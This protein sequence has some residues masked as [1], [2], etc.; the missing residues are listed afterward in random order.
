MWTTLMDDLQTIDGPNAR[1]SLVEVADAGLTLRLRGLKG[2]PGWTMPI[3]EA[4]H[5]SGVRRL[6]DGFVLDIDVFPDAAV[7]GHGRFAVSLIARLA[8]DSSF[9]EACLC[10][11][12]I[13]AADAAFPLE[14]LAFPGRLNVDG[15]NDRSD[16][17]YLL[18]YGEGI[19][20]DADG[21]APHAMKQVSFHDY[22]ITMPLVA[23]LSGNGA[24]VMAITQQGHDHGIRPGYDGDISLQL[25]QLACLGTWRYDRSWRMVTIG[26][27]GV[28]TLAKIARSELKRSGLALR[29]LRDKVAALPSG[30]C[31][32]PGG[33]HLWCHMDTLTTQLVSD[34]A[35]TGIRALMVMGRPADS[36]A[37]TTVREA[38]FASGPY[39]Q[40]YDV[41]PPGSVR[42]LEWR[43]T[44]PPEGASHGFPHQLRRNRDGFFDYAWVHLPMAHSEHHWAFTDA[45]GSDGRVVR[46]T[47]AIHEQY[48]VQSYRRC[49]LFHREV[50]AEYGLPMLDKLGSTAVF[51]DICTTMFGLECADPRHPCERRQDVD[52][53]KKALTDFIDTQRIVMSEDGKWWAVDLAHGFEGGLNYDGMESL[54]NITLTDYEFNSNNWNTEFNLEHRIPFFSMIMGHTVASTF[55]WG[56]G[57]DRHSETRRAKDAFAALLGGNPI[58]VVDPAHPLH[59]GTARWQDFVDTAKAFDVL[60]NHTL[61]VPI[62]RFDV[63]G[64]HHGTTRF[65]NGVVVDANVGPFPADGLDAGEYRVYSPSGDPVAGNGPAARA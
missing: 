61:G 1:L 25:V 53:R 55:W 62:D 26:E 19:L 23:A 65:E 35:A 58:F 33:T 34:L 47:H 17:Q 16:W 11:I 54:D 64:K 59:S 52:L 10:D 57:Q 29:S 32:A 41:F 18:P 22:K 4:H 8:G 36:T 27:G 51:Y 37:M 60:R 24:G 6:A 56:R 48:P 12:E 28:N 3:G 45:L 20:V 40:T 15:S 63:H 44:Y 14:D 31:G 43:N 7:A 39:F 2:Q 42:E 9:P 49:Q 38:G 21:T 50:I 13:V 46:R 30:M 5:V